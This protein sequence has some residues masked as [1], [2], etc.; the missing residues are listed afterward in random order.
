MEKKE[1][2]NLL[3]NVFKKLSYS[4]GFTW[5]KADK[6]K[7]KTTGLLQNAKVSVVDMIESFK[8]GFESGREQ[9]DDNAGPGAGSEPEA[10]KHEPKIE[11][12]QPGVGLKDSSKKNRPLQDDQKI[13]A[14]PQELLDV[15][16]EK[17]IEEITQEVGKA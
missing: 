9:I 11:K 13:K 16:F 8:N 1:D 10:T 15:D 12:P 14:S 6:L 17:E 3:E 5:K 7:N 4:I 2:K